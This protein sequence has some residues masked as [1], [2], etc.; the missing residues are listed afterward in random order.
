[1]IA[2]DCANATKDYVLGRMIVAAGLHTTPD[3]LANTDTPL[4][5]LLA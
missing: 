1:V 2:L 3:Q 5:N 4:K